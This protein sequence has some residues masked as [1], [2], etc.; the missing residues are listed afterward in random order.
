MRAFSA[1]A[2]AGLLAVPALLGSTVLSV[3]RDGSHIQME[4]DD[5]EATVDWV[6]DST[7]H[8]IRTWGS[9]PARP[10]TQQG[11]VRI[12]SKNLKVTISRKGVM[13]KVADSD[14]KPLVADLTEV[15]RQGDLLTWER[16]AEGPIQ[17]YGLGNR[18]DERMR[19]RRHRIEASFPF[20]LTTAHYAECHATT[21]AYSFDLARLRPDRYRT[22]VR[23]ARKIDYYF[24]YGETVKDIL[25]Q[26]LL[27]AG[28]V[29]RFTLENFRP[30]P[31][32]RQP[33]AAYVLDSGDGSWEALRRVVQ[34]VVN[35][36][37]SGMILPAF[38][39]SRFR[40]TGVRRRAEQLATVV[41]VLIGEQ[42]PAFR[43]RLDAYWLTYGEESR[44]R[45]YPFIRP[46]PL[47]FPRDPEAGRRA[48]QFMLGDE[49]LVAPLLGEENRRA[50]YLPSGSWT[51]LRTNQVFPGRQEISIDAEPDE[52]PLF[53]RN[54][55]IVPLGSEPMELHY[56]P[57][58]GGEFFLFE[59][60]GAEYSQVHAAPAGDLMRLEIESKKNR[61]YEWIVHH[62]DP[63]RR[64]LSNGE[65]LLGSS[66]RYDS[67]LRNLHVRVLALRG[68]D[69]IINLLFR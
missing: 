51:R 58:L 40:N 31:A 67:R 56:F 46:M 38:E 9:Q 14:G 25:E 34:Q 7:F 22:E 17:Y 11:D 44:D 42:A 24:M 21:G 52:L 1:A 29:D 32:G 49:L 60:D 61:E 36:S 5:G 65:D 3:H 19:L 39:P 2:S 4:L 37:L 50:I 57:K 30:G 23:V 53:S 13:V 28:P 8:F 48:D 10:Q 55:A 68:E 69:R 16:S 45:G 41:P 54:G 62:V 63:P 12:E 20:L 43:G 59:P 47:Q 66:W 15:E 35:G 26:Y 33:K 64:V 18:A 6:S 27:V